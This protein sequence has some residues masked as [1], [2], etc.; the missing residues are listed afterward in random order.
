[1]RL[2]ALPCLIAATGAFAQAPKQDAA[3]KRFEVQITPPDY[4]FRFT[5]TVTIPGRP[6]ITLALSG[7]GARGVAHIGVLERLDRDGIPV[8]AV[9][10]TSIGSFIGGLY[11]MGYSGQEIEDL[12]RTQDFNRAFLD[13]MRRQPGQTLAEQEDRSA[14]LLRLESDGKGGFRFAQGLQSGLPVQR[15]LESLFARGAFFSGGDFDRLRVPFRA[16]A[17]NLATGEGRV[18]ASGDL[19][20]SVRASMTVPGGFQPVSIGG[21]PF[22]DG[23]LV[24]NLPVDMAKASFPGAFTLAVDISSPLASSP[25]TSFFSVAAR[26]LDLT[27]ERR[28][29]ESRQHADFLLRP[30]LGDVSFTDY[31]AQFQQLLQAGRAAYDAESDA[32]RAAVLARWPSP[33]LPPGT[34]L[35]WD[36]T[37][38]PPESSAALARLRAVNPA[39]RDVTIALQQL[40]V[41]GWARN[42]WGELGPG[43]TL[44]IHAEPWPAITAWRVEAPEDLRPALEAEAR[45]ALPPGTIFNPNTFGALLSRIVH[46]R[47][48]EGAP[49]AD[50]RGSGFDADRG[51]ATLCFSEPTVR[52]IEVRPPEGKPLRTDYL[53]DL[54][55]PLMD[56]PVRTDDLQRRV[57]LG[58]E[59]LDLGEL[60]WREKALG[61]DGVELDLLP[62]PQRKQS[63]DVF[64]G[65]ETSLGGE[66]GLAY[67]ARN[68]GGSGIGV[69]L[70]AARNRLQQEAS[71]TLRGPFRAFP[72]AGLELT[73]SGQ[74]QRLE[75]LFAFPNAEFGGL[76]FDAKLRAVDGAF[77]GYLR[78]GDDG[79]GKLSLEA[80]QRKA[81]YLY[82]GL[83]KTRT[84]RAAT[85]S[86][87]WD[88]FD[89][90]FLPRQGL[91]LRTRFT[92]GHALAGDLPQT[93][94]SSVYARARGLQPLGAHFGLDLDLEGGAGSNL[95]LDRW[96][97]FGG[98]AALIGS[99]SLSLLAPK[100]AAARFGVPIRFQGPLSL[101]VEIEPRLDTARFAG[102]GG[103]LGGAS[104]VKATGAGLLLRTTLASFF[105]EGGYGFLRYEGAPGLDSRAHGS[106]HLSIAT[107]PFDL[108]R[109]R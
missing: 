41:H 100:F 80:S 45:K 66:W 101:D 38:L 16:L 65:W 58:E 19:A 61:Q 52:A 107:R 21:H 67:A 53:K 9:A 25:A 2:G 99:D 33:P 17:T 56:R 11:A 24:E 22:V 77:G 37:G 14:S 31:N 76:P 78:F 69:D 88:D 98:N 86:A 1:M 68:L 72:G 95:P 35:V 84:E 91:L 94:F 57:A 85:L 87:E 15:V 71:V 36:G 6:R 109:R 70:D 29:W 5:P 39:E 13:L 83:N 62:V 28:Q 34:A 60:R 82:P 20:E 42:A 104:A 32:L 3:P 23:A 108:W 44:T 30:K 7:G 75:T 89:R 18:F 48:L 26:S 27:I 43:P 106:F 4:V 90:V 74:E 102:L 54:M 81:D 55:L 96:W 103:Q 46:G 59:R 8:D 64:L 105:L 49:L 97:P 79:T 93:D 10:G 92:A 40:L 73:V 63:I 51:I 50:V 47:A 12:F